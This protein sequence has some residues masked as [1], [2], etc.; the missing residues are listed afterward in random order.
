MLRPSRNSVHTAVCRRVNWT[1]PTEVAGGGEDRGDPFAGP[2]RGRIS[3]L[4]AATR[5]IDRKS[6]IDED[7]CTMPTVPASMSPAIAG[8]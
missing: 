8:G 3:L 7:P 5:I 1:V 4:P 6:S 2:D